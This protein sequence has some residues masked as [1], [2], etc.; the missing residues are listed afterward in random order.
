MDQQ[1]LRKLE[2]QCI[3]EN[4]PEC[5]A[6]CPLHVDGRAF[7]GAAAQG[8]WTEAL[9]V[10][11]KT[12]P[13]PNILG[14]ICDAP[15]EVRCKRK[16][17]GQAIRLGALERACVTREAV[18]QRLQKL[19]GK[20]GRIAILGSGLSGLTVAWDCLRKGY[21]VRIFEPGQ[22][23]GESLADRYPDRLPQDVIA[24]ET[25]LLLSLGMEVSFEVP[26]E[27]ADFPERCLED[28]E[29]LYLSLDVLSGGTWPLERDAEG[30][31]Q[32]EPGIQR[33]S[34]EGVFAGGLEKD[35]RISP[36]RQAAEGRWAAN[37]IDRYLQK[38]SLTASREKEGPVS[39]RLFT[40]LDGVTP[41]PAVVP[42]DPV[43]G[44]DETEAVTEAG[45]CLQCQCLECVKVC[46]YLERFGAYP[47]KY[48]R[49]IYNNE[50]I[51][52]GSRQANR[53]INSCSLCGLCETVC[54]EDFAMQDLCLQ[55]RESMVRRGKMPPSAHE[56]ALLDMAFSRSERFALARHEPGHSAGRQAFFPGC[57]LSGSA[58]GQ[59]EDVYAYLRSRLSGG[60]GLILNCCGA[61]AYW[62]GSRESFS[63]SLDALKGHW[64][65]LGEPELIVACSTCLRMFRDYAPEIPT[66]SLWLVLEERGLPESASSSVGE[67]LAVH[68]PCTTRSEPEIQAAVRR[69]LTNLGVSAEELSLGRERTECCGFGGLMQNANPDLAREVVRRRAERSGRDYLTYC[70]VCRD[71]LA[72]V[73]KRA[74][75][76]LDLLF[77]DPANP[78][79]AAREKTGW[80]ER[81]ENRSR[82]KDRLL[83]ELWSEKTMEKEAHQDITLQMTPEV[84]A[85]LEQRR[86]LVEDVQQ[87]IHHAE[88]SGEKFYNASNGRYKAS[89][90]PYKTMFW[91][92]YR[93]EAEGFTVFNAYC[94]RMELTCP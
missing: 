76:L 52:I 36:I 26:V 70:A 91:V 63:A 19:P 50:S 25:D 79:P 84:K 40:S 82:L 60:V 5:T 73:N 88:R 37:S 62:S 38:V 69:L 83:E 44:Y 24:A 32:I 46:V 71:S 41:L 49:E 55:V 93:P 20:K 53:L 15:C 54:P 64:K 17:A 47:K 75:H 2:N 4:P 61:P 77:P 66:R 43:R 68:D 18:P 31:V 81:Q 78:D 35:G 94:H 3:Q 12:M 42:S 27:D 7:A 74:L 85:L 92:E 51:V 6:A 57:Q 9:K 28:F 58:P 89:F 14:R 30:R 87:V 80:S 59:V 21:P 23:L 56:F 39:T 13:L 67:V 22:A 65:N 72:S 48:A 10:L 45:R 90:R 16:E 34:R 1:E 11:R 29:A 8:N 33:T 86:I